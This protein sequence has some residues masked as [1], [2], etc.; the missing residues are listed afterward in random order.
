MKANVPKAKELVLLYGFSEESQ[1]K[2]QIQTILEQMNLS[3]R[4]ITEDLL[5]QTVGWCAEIPGF[6]KRETEEKTSSIRPPI[7]TQAM[8]LCGLEKKKLDMLLLAMQRQN[9]HIPLKAIV[10]AHN[11]T[12]EFHVLLEE[13]Q[14]EREAIR[15]QIQER[16]KQQE[17]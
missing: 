4:W 6:V 3:S 9:L 8:V 10:T 12:W 15:V 14:Q 7:D 5:G 16:K 2:E 11:M 17:Q 1:K 13:L